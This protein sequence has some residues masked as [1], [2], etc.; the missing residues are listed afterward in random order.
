M[1]SVAFDVAA[2]PSSQ[3]MTRDQCTVLTQ[4]SSRAVLFR[5]LSAAN[6]VVSRGTPVALLFARDGVVQLLADRWQDHQTKLGKHLARLFWEG[7][8]T[9]AV[10]E[11]AL[12]KRGFSANHLINLPNLD[13]LSPTQMLDIR[14][15]SAMVLVY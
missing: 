9:V 11:D 7:G 3:S 14:F 13:L 5:A 12:R 8:V 2:L 4:R 1:S 15:R 10:D 6:K